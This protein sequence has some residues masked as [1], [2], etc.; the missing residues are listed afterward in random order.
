MCG[1]GHKY[2]GLTP[3]ASEAFIDKLAL[4]N[5]YVQELWSA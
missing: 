4:Q 5:K 2:G 3:A 1:L